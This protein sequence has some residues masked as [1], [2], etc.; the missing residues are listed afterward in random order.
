MIFYKLKWVKSRLWVGI[1]ETIQIRNSVD[2]RPHNIY[3]SLLLCLH[4]CF[5]AKIE[6]TIFLIIVSYTIVFKIFLHYYFWPYTTLQFI[7]DCG[8]FL[9]FLRGYV[10]MMGKNCFWLINS[11]WRFLK[12]YKKQKIFICKMS[13]PNVWTCQK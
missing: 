7:F 5:L 4:L 3:S 2:F 12:N 10:L 8:H 9:V 1:N 11:V 13:H 6:L